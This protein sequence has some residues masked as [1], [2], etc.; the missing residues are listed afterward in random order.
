MNS[1]KKETRPG[2]IPD[3]LYFSFEPSEDWKKGSNAQIVE[4]LVMFCGMYKIMTII[5]FVVCAAAHCYALFAGYIFLK[6]SC[7]DPVG[8]TFTSFD[9]WADDKLDYDGDAWSDPWTDSD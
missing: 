8:T 2:Q 5:A 3:K 1:K 6:S 4:S 9:T 7:A